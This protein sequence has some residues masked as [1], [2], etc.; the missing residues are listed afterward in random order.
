MPGKN[1]GC[2][3]GK[4]TRNMIENLIEEFKD[5]KKEIKSEFVD[6][7]KTNIELYNHLSNRLPPW[8]T[9]IGAIGIAIISA[10]FGVIIGGFF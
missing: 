1:N 4:V 7:K 6:M 2:A 3:Y 9:A 10:I 8:A 5:F